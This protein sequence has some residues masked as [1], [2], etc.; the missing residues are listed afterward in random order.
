MEV[1]NPESIEYDSTVPTQDE[2]RYRAQ[3]IYSSQNRV[4]TKNDYEAYCYQ[5]PPQFGSI[6]RVSV[7]NDPS[8]T[9]KR[10]CLYV[11]STTQDG[12]LTKV[13]DTTKINLK[14]WLNKN[15]MISDMIDIK[16]AKIINVGFDY[17]FVVDDS[18]DRLQVLALVNS[19]VSELFADKQYIAEPI[20][21]TDIYQT[22]NKTVGVVDTVKVR[23]RVLN[24]SGYS[25]LSVDIDDILSRDGTYINTPS[26]CVLEVKYPGEDIRGIIV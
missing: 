6:K 16:D 8:G 25:N 22:I 17:E 13:N 26:N 12:Y 1:S 7:Y 9:N 21:I 15:K 10:L 11:I 3:A 2:I 4:V 19:R 23:P 18:Y 20:Y 5:M 24:T 14:T